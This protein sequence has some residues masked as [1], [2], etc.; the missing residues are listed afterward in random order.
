VNTQI[1]RE[2]IN[3]TMALALM[4]FLFNQGKISERT[5]KTILKKY[6]KKG[7]VLEDEM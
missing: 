3:Y 4:K 1:S 5:Y 6:G 7:L 2:Q